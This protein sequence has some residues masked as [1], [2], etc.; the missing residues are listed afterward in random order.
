ME[1]K[2]TESAE[3]CQGLAQPQKEHRWLE[4]LVGT[5]ACTS[6][7]SAG[8]GAPLETLEGSETVRSL[9]GLWFVAE[10]VSSMPGGTMGTMVMTLG[11]DPDKGCYVGTWIGSMMNWLCIYDKGELDASGK[12]LLLYSV[13]PSMTG[14]GGTRNYRDVIEFLDDDTRTLRGQSQD[15][16]G[17]WQD[18]MKVEYRRQR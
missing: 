9:G 4:Q 6:R 18:M 3:P 17:Q 16:Q 7:M 10:S 12:R 11:Y 8:P 13:G 2:T 1:A 15:D 5:W 14:D